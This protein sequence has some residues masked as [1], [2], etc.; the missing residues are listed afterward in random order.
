MAPGNADRAHTSRR[1]HGDRVRIFYD[2]RHRT[3]EQK[4]L[5][6]NFQ[7]AL[8]SE[9]F[10]SIEG[11]LSV[12]SAG[13]FWRKK[14]PPCIATDALLTP[15]EDL[16]AL[17]ERFFPAPFGYY[18]GLNKETLILCCPIRTF[19]ETVISSVSHHQPRKYQKLEL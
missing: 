4:I 1:A 7:F 5:E 13:K 18:Q 9:D 11:N 10:P 3:T 19:G 8:S 16:T 12:S 14:S 2:E 17:H 6:T 15:G